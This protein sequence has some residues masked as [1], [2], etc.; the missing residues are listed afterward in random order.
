M[1]WQHPYKTTNQTF[2]QT[3][4]EAKDANE[5][6]WTVTTDASAALTFGNSFH[7]VGVQ[8]PDEVVANLDVTVYSVEQLPVA[9][10]SVWSSSSIKCPK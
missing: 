10:E 2:L 6:Q 4:K 3:N 1:H 5:I 8:Y 7:G 9:K